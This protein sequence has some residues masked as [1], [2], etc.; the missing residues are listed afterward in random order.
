MDREQQNRVDM[1][2]ATHDYMME[3]QAVWANSSAMQETVAD[4]EANI[5]VIHRISAK[6]SG[7]TSGVTADKE[8]AR[9]AYEDLIF[10]LADQVG[11][12][13]AQKE[14]L[15][16]EAQVDITRN[17]LD[18]LTND[19]LINIGDTVAG[20]VTTN[21]TALAP[22]LVTQADLDELAILKTRFAGVKSAP[23]LAIVGRA[24]Q[25]ESLPE[26]LNNTSR[27]LH[28]RLDRQMSRFRRTH[29]EFFAGYEKARIIINRSATNTANGTADTTTTTTPTN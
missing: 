14:K 28:R 7:N 16:L 27:L 6:Q 5:D 26:A 8:Q 19:D 22:F 29:P 3:N 15:D 1:F 24:T 9:T 21:L 17:G 25:T 2:N 11:A 18:K 10:D 20:L 13:A 23:R 4:L 12:Y